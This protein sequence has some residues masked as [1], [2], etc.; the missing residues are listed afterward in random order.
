MRQRELPDINMGGAVDL[1]L[2]PIGKEGSAGIDAGVVRIAAAG[3]EADNAGMQ[4]AARTVGDHQ[5]PAA[6]ALARIN[7]ACRKNA[8]A[9]MN[10]AERTVITFV[11][12][13]QINDWQTSL[14][15]HIGEIKTGLRQ[16]IAPASNVGRLPRRKASCIRRPCDPDRRDVVDIS[17]QFEQRHVIVEHCIKHIERVD[18][19]L[20]YIIALAVGRLRKI[21]LANQYLNGRR[22]DHIPFPIAHTMRCRQHPLGRGK[23]AAVINQRAA[24]ERLRCIGNLGNQQ[25]HQP[26]IVTRI[27]WTAADNS[28]LWRRTLP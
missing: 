4:E 11:T 27:N 1:R 23:C 13:C 5:R 10:R 18:N 25:R 7:A 22:I 19:N 17:V 20:F 9:E 12:G 16:G 2:D 15:R 8:G 6:I 26:R 21:L 3:A 28:Q 14:V 24:A